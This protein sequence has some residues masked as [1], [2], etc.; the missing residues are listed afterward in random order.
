MTPE[1]RDTEK[2]R[3]KVGICPTHGLMEWDRSWDD[4]EFRTEDEGTCP[5]L[6][7]DENGCDEPLEGPFTVIYEGKAA[8]AR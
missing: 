8:D 5:L 3:W 2:G 1:P 7:S 6:M 4:P